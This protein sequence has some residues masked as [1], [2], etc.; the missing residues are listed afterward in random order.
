MI[1]YKNLYDKDAK[2]EI[3]KDLRENKC[4]IDFT[5]SDGTKRQMISTLKIDFLPK[6]ILQENYKSE[7]IE[8]LVE[9][10]FLT[11]YDI[12]KKN[13]RRFKYESIN[14]IKIILENK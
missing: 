8:E 1:E 4:Q 13:W 9:K 7:P 5:K 12:E 2:K 14:S 6:E 11:V 3:I 10:D